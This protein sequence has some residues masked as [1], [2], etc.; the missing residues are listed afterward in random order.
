MK[1][2][3][4]GSLLSGANQNN[5]APWDRGLRPDQQDIVFASTPDSQVQGSDDVLRP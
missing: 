3:V 5:A 1:Y 4:L 2:D